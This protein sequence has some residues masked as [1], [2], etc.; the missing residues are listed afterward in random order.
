VRRRS[1][2]A[3][4]LLVGT[5]AIAV[6][7]GGIVGQQVLRIRTATDAG[8]GLLASVSESLA[9]MPEVYGATEPGDVLPGGQTDAG[10]A[11]VPAPAVAPAAA[12]AAASP[13]PILYTRIPKPVLAGPRRIG[14]QA[15]HWQ[16]EKAPP[17]LWRLLTQTG[18][19]W[20]GV[21]EV[22]INLDIANRIKAILEPTGIVVDVL[23]TT[24]P[25]GYVADAFVA[26]HGDGD[27]TGENSGFKM[28]FS[29]RRT[30]FEAD[31]L[32]TIK[33]VYGAATGLAYDSGRISRNMIGYFAFSWQRNKYATAPHT[34]SVILEMGYVSNDG[35][36]ELMTERADVVARGIAQGLLRFLEDHP[37]E[38][39]FGQDL[40]VPATPQ[41]APPRP[42]PT[43]AG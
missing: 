31:L 3:G 11:P 18:T 9:Q 12:P 32:E 28:A 8:P 36:R 20:N 37:R 19:A 7:V 38:K 17:E 10:P 43:P 2:L 16:T 21:T 33:S 26:L 35:D 23:P 34:P 39:L 40:L 4:L 30:P 24:I 25:P 14:I 29:A 22:E 6:V 5:A 42:S 1:G 13:T 41:F 15:G 27:G